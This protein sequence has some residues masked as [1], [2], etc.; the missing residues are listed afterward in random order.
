MLRTLCWGFILCAVGG[1]ADTTSYR[2]EKQDWL[3]DP[4][5]IVSRNDPLYDT[6]S[7]QPWEAMPVGGGDLSGMARFDGD[8]HL[9]LT[10]SDAWGFQEPADAPLGSRFFNNVSPGHIRIQFGEGGQELSNRYFRQRLDLYRGR[11]SLC[12]GNESDGVKIH[13]WGHPSRKIM[14]VEVNDPHSLLGPA[15]IELSEWRSTMNVGSNA[16]TIYASEILERAAR[17][18]LASA[19][20][21]DY[22]G[23]DADPLKGRGMAVAVKAPPVQ[24][25][26]CTSNVLTATMRASEDNSEQYHIIISAAVTSTGDPLSKAK[27]ELEE[28]VFIPIKQLREEHD[29]WWRDYW[30]KSF[31]RI[32]SPDKEANWLCAAYHVHLYT[33]ASTNRGQVPAKWDGG[34]GLMRRD[35]RNWGISEWVQEVRFTFMP[36]YTANQLEM[37]KGLS[38]FY[39]R[40]VPYL[41]T[42][43]EKIWGLPGLWIPETVTP[44][45]HAEDFVLTGDQKEVLEHY[46]PWNPE[47]SAY[48]RFEWYNPYVGFLFTAGLEVCHHYLTYYRYSGDAGFL[49]EEAYPILSGV[50]EFIAELLQKGDDG[51]YHLDPA[52]ALETWWMVR[53]PADTMDGIRSIFAEFIRLAQDYGSDKDIAEKCVKI[54]A[55]LPEPPRGQWSENGGIDTSVDVFAPAVAEATQTTRTNAENPALYRIY[56]F[57]LS[58]IDSPDYDIAKR[59]FDHRISSLA[60]GWSM[61]PIWAARLGLGEKACDLLVHHA[62]KYNRFRYGGWDSNDSRTFPDNLAAAPFLDAGGLSAF[63][64]QE[65]LIQSHNGV[66]RILPAVTA[67]WSGVFRLLAEGGFLVASEFHDGQV[68][69]IEIK[70]L[71]GKTCVLANPWDSNCIIRRGEQVMLETNQPMIRFETEAGR[72]YLIDSA[73]DPIR[74]YTPASLQ[75]RRN[76]IPGLPGRDPR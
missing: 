56:P 3:L 68:R 39:S 36:L 6:V 2:L 13:V 76:E 41:E 61:D 22:F 18:H 62:R 37:A 7:E 29:Q 38:D 8:L 71:L 47:V 53:D 75:D 70:S 35:E 10:Q 55:G 1:S 11:V 66:L 34:A 31:L 40:M 14:V 20:M 33:L 27:R 16:D 12:L 5:K 52:N 4:E 45:G 65:I 15:V 69:F 30:G 24:P 63:A 57:G 58:G 9:H 26:A 74:G 72:T 60:N 23:D 64:L 46:Q 50:C 42:Q 49:E 19:G 28:A 51:K 44:W 59:T 73:N 32:E 54:L 48:G 21:Q 67:D 17:P 43:T 25:V